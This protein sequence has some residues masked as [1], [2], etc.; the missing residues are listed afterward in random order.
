LTGKPTHRDPV[1]DLARRVPYEAT[2]ESFA[3]PGKLYGSGA[4]EV[5]GPRCSSGGGRVRLGN[6]ERRG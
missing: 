6:P 3:H 2:A 1:D 5:L 4:A